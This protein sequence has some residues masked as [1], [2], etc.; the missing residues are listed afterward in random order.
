MERDI[1]NRFILPIIDLLVV[2]FLLGSMIY[3][4]INA[5]ASS[6]S[7]PISGGWTIEITGDG[8]YDIMPD[9]DI[10]EYRLTTALGAVSNLTLKREFSGDELDSATLRIYITAADVVVTLDGDEIYSTSDESAEHLD[11]G[12]GYAFIEIPHVDDGGVI[13]ISVTSTDDGGLSAIP[14]L[15][16]TTSDRSYAYFIHEDWLGILISIFIFIFGLVVSLLSILFMRLSADYAKLFDIG[17][18]SI[19]GGVW[20]LSILNV[21][22]LFGMDPAKNS[23]MGYLAVSVAFLPLFSLDMR[24]R[25]GMSQK[26]QGAIKRIMYVNMIVAALLAVLHFTGL[27]SYV[28]TVPVIHLLYSV[29]CLVI[30]LVGV[31]HFRNMELAEKIYHVDFVFIV[32]AG[33]IYML[34]YYLRTFFRIIAMNYTDFWFPMMTFI[35]VVVQLIA[36]LVHIYGMLMNQAEEEVLRRLAYNDALTGLYNRVRAEEEFKNL[37]ENNLPYAF[38]NIDLNGLKTINDRYGHAQGD[39]FIAAFG[40]ILK[41]VFGEYGPCVRM[42]GDEFLV[43]MPDMHI[44]KL[45]GLIEEME[46][47]EREESRHMSFEI[48]AAYGVA[49][50]SEME[51][52]VAEQLYSI[53]DQRMYEMKV[54]SKKA[55]ED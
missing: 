13:T 21:P 50:S 29:D 33:F 52:P 6:L 45:D 2:V 53:A 8:G 49:K 28:T 16:L 17:V 22:L 27:L 34:T 54:A 15:A 37:D 36:Y 25:S 11:D 35:F 48:D 51:K 23:E 14:D 55:R 5:K 31:E 19:F 46:K 40:R 47:K 4:I 30:L 24:M 39:V 12:R 43:I 44:A 20:L 9:M 7:Y 32:I 42:G 38:L 10:D 3:F 26:D 41:S 18:F 1:K